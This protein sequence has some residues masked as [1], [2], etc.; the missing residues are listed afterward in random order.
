[1]DDLDLVMDDCCLE[2]SS[3]EEPSWSCWSDD[4]CLDD[5]SSFVYTMITDYSSDD[6]AQVSFPEGARVIVI[7]QDEDGR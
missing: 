3:D 2:F 1:M 6:P 5:S 7:D 4:E